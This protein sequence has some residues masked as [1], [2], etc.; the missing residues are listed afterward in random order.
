MRKLIIFLILVFSFQL[1][2]SAEDWYCFYNLNTGID[3]QMKEHAR[4]EEMY[5]KHSQVSMVQLLNKN[6]VVELEKSYTKAQKRLR[7]ISILIDTYMII[8]ESKR[9]IDRIISNQNKLIREIKNYPMYSVFAISKEYDFVNKTRLL[10]Q[11]ITGLVLTGNSI[12]QLDNADRKI[13]SNF[14][15]KELS[16]IE[17]SSHSAYRSVVYAKQRLNLQKIQWTN[18]ATEDYKLVKDIINNAKKI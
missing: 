16:D 18:W 7:A 11:Y 2:L 9:I 6:E 13:L 8:G 12:L 4:Q 5:K 14:I 17:T 1:N 15:I 10:S 3:V